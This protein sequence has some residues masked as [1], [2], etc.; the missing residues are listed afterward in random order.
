MNYPPVRISLSVSS[1]TEF[2]RESRQE[3]S[4]DGPAWDLRC[5]CTTDSQS[6]DIIGATKAYVSVSIDAGGR[7]EGGRPIGQLSQPETDEERF[8]SAD[9]GLREAEFLRFVEFLRAYGQRPFELEL[10]IYSS[11]ITEQ[12]CFDGKWDKTPFPEIHTFSYWATTD[13]NNPRS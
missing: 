4:A 2:V 6:R 8:L 13:A 10:G 3:A 7:F 1:Y 11:E 5:N 12:E 9:I